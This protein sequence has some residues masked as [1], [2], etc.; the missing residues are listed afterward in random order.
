MMLFLVLEKEA[1]HL[2]AAEWWIEEVKLKIKPWWQFEASQSQH[3]VMASSKLSMEDNHNRVR[4]L[5]G[6]P[7][8]SPIPNLPHMSLMDMLFWNCRGA[9]NNKFKGNIKELIKIHKPDILVLMETKVE[10][11][12]MGMF[13][14]SL[15]LTTLAHV[16]PIGRSGG[17]WMLDVVES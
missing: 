16:D 13:F 8:Q 11:Q 17:I 12:S 14:N 5:L 7:E 10:F 15:G 1:S 3:L 4:E 9:G 2:I 6:T